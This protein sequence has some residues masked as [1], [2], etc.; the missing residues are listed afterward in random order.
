MLNNSVHI[1]DK[2]SPNRM[3]G[4]INVIFEILCTLYQRNKKACI[5]FFHFGKFVFG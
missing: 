5:G 1:R 4:A 2:K 3:I